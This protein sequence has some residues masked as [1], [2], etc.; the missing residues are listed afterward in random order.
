MFESNLLH[1]GA[2]LFAVSY[3]AST[4]DR[5]RVVLISTLVLGA[6]VEVAQEAGTAT[7]ARAQISD[8]DGNDYTLLLHQTTTR[9]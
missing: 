2:I 7:G 5:D 8:H 4:G 3:S 1:A 6:Q 9:L